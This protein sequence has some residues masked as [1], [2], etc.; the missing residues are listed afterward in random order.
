MAVG[1]IGGNSLGKAPDTRAPLVQLSLDHVRAL[2]AN[3]APGEIL[4]GRV[5]ADLGD[6][7]FAL[8]VRGQTVIASSQTPLSLDSVVKLLVHSTGDQ[9]VFRLLTATFPDSATTT[10]AASRAAALGL[11]QTP[12]AVSALQAF[13]QVGAALDP[14]RLKDAAAQLQLLPPAQVPQRALALGL[15][16]NAGLPTT[17]PFIALAERS[18]TGVLP[19]PAAALA[20]FKTTAPAAVQTTGQAAAGGGVGDVMVP[21]PRAT[22]PLFPS[23]LP[24]GAPLLIRQ[25]S[26]GLTAGTT[27]TVSSMNTVAPAVVGDQ[28]LISTTKIPT[29]GVPTVTALPLPIPH[30]S[31]PGAGAQSL[32]PP[33]PSVPTPSAQPLATVAAPVVPAALSPATPT[34][35]SP[36]MALSPASTPSTP[37]VPIAL[38]PSVVSAALIASVPTLSLASVSTTP[39]LL[40]TTIPD[41]GRDGANAAMQALSL[42][43]VRPRQNSETHSAPTPSPLIHRLGAQ[44]NA[45]EL[46][47]QVTEV[48]VRHEPPS[49][50]DAA[51]AHVMREQIAET[52]IKPRSLADYDMVLALP[53]Q[54]QGQPTPAR[55]AVAE[56]H[57]AGGTATFV[58]VDAELTHLGP[59]SVRLSGI[60]GG[61][62]AITVMATG[63]A[64]AALT[65]ALPDLSDS[66]RDLGLTAGLRVADLTEDHPHG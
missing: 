59:L 39:S 35:S 63:P 47:T 4:T 53:M 37:V 22:A 14:V 51:V 23:A 36:L 50:M 38:A 31:S 24:S 30:G 3:L 16:A 19:N 6:G 9:P 34:S 60:D 32:L 13:E 29:A 66:L 46:P 64:L 25:F 10:T 52:V 42:A 5:G 18:A 20:A 54:A 1:D 2:A 56:R 7:K 45:A 41:V 15:L 55:L 11:P 12:A 17:A 58:R 44:V 26:P 27:A 21:Q 62:M 65:A 49:A 40:N 57:T 33:T 8:T 61:A 28:P 48:A 43:G